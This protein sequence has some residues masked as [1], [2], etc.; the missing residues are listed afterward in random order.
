MSDYEVST[1]DFYDRWPNT[2]LEPTPTAPSLRLRGVHR[3]PP[4]PSTSRSSAWVSFGSL[5]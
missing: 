1:F 5:G 3:T 4:V 2:A